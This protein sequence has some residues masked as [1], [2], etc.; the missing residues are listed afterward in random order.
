M[1]QNIVN[2]LFILHHALLSNKMYNFSFSH[3]DKLWT[4]LVIKHVW[5]DFN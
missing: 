4:I 1:T 3:D 2:N 5:N